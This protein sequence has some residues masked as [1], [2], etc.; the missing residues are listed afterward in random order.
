MR[1]KELSVEA[2]LEI[3][4]GQLCGANT[5]E[6]LSQIV[7]DY[8]KIQESSAQEIEKKR[9]V[10][11]SKC[12]ERLWMA[13]VWRD[14]QLDIIKRSYEAEVKQIEREHQV[15]AVDFC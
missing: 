7:A 6:R 9:T 3:Q 12:Q 13:G 15:K 1:S 14:Y 4:E 8:C 5:S 2:Q 11:R 10:V